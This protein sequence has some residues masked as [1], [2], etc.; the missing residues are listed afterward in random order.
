MSYAYICCIMHHRITL[1]LWRTPKVFKTWN[2]NETIQ[3]TMRTFRKLFLIKNL[4]SN[5]LLKKQ[6]KK[7]KYIQKWTKRKE[8]LLTFNKLD[9]GS[10]L[11]KPKLHNHNFICFTCWLPPTPS[12]MKYRM[13]NFFKTI[14]IF[15]SSLLRKIAQNHI[16]T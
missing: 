7:S 5:K 1:C 10:S 9:F 14:N 2:K 8:N 3:D 11:D 6:G 15:D 13:I 16:I 12:H 4:Y